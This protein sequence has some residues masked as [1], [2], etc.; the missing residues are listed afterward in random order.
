MLF[1]SIDVCNEYYFFQSKLLFSVEI[2]ILNGDWL[3]YA[4]RNNLFGID[5]INAH[6]HANVDHP[7]RCNKEVYQ[8]TRRTFYNLGLS[9]SKYKY[10]FLHLCVEMCLPDGK[11]LHI[12]SDVSSGSLFYK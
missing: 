11:P 12:I 10:F 1:K 5:G 4:N 3:C 9:F 2:E 7:T 8:P 6:C